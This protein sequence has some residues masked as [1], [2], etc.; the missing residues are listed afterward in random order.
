[1]ST[2]RSKVC[3]VRSDWQMFMGKFLRKWPRSQTNDT[4]KP[5]K[6]W[7]DRRNRATLKFP[8]ESKISLRI[9]PA[10]FVSSAIFWHWSLWDFQSDRWHS[11][12][13]YATSL[14]FPQAGKLPMTPHRWHCWKESN[15]LMTAAEL[16]TSMLLFISSCKAWC[17]RFLS[18]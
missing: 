14:Q 13:Q 7:K 10:L 12:E 17:K 8:C 3:A 6:P 5:I 18:K 11:L 4:A 2:W 15:I 1:M 16:P 9:L